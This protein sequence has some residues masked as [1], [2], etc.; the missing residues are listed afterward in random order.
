M[1]SSDIL[2]INNN[3]EI[4]NNMI[5]TLKMCT[6][7]YDKIQ[8]NGKIPQILYTFTKNDINNKNKLRD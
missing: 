5:N 6:I 1:L 2:I 3:G 4:S 7:A 8:K